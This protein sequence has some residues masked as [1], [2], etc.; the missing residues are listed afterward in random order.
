M[1]YACILAVLAGTTLG[2]SASAGDGRYSAANPLTPGGYVRINWVRTLN[3]QSSG[4]QNIAIVS[5]RTSRQGTASTL[6]RIRFDASGVEPLAEAAVE[7]GDEIVV[8]SEI[9][10]APFGAVKDAK[11]H[12]LSV[13]P[14]YSCQQ[15]LPSQA[16]RLTKSGF[17]DCKNPLPF[18]SVKLK[19]K[20]ACSGGGLCDG[21]YLLYAR[22][23]GA[24]ASGTLKSGTS[25]T[26]DGKAIHAAVELSIESVAVDQLGSVSTGIGKILV[27]IGQLDA[28]LPTVRGSA[29]TEQGAG[30]LQAALERQRTGIAALGAP[31]RHMDVLAGVLKAATWVERVR[32]HA[33]DVEGTGADQRRGEV[34]SIVGILR[35][36]DGRFL[37]ANEGAFLDE[38]VCPMA[39]DTQA[40]LALVNREDQTLGIALAALCPTSA[41]G[42]RRAPS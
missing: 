38:V 17:T 4:G 3:A 40:M 33:S 24:N 29:G 15:M 22:P 14:N 21:T 5:V 13:C 39:R 12:L 36:I 9:F 30:A 16:A 2:K 27:A 11:T 10:T 7:N 37:T 34:E 6:T 19:Q 20:T 8:D 23:E 28:S 1:R 18:T 25:A 32:G 31:T 35:Q 42:T 26:I 41:L